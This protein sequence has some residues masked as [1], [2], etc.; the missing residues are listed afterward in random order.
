[1]MRDLDTTEIEEVEWYTSWKSLYI[2]I[3]RWISDEK[4]SCLNNFELDT[5]IW[6]QLI[7]RAQCDASSYPKTTNR[8]Y[9]GKY[10][11]DKC[12]E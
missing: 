12:I 4:G 3:I 11:T 8:E 1:M 6:D 2:I 9:S 5:L 10:L 7:F